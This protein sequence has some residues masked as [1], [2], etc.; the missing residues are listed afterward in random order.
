MKR[1]N[2]KTVK[3]EKTNKLSLKI[4][5]REKPEEEKGLLRL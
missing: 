4:K 1:P 2:T 5:D 3:I